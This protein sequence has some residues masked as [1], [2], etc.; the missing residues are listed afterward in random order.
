MN[1]GKA[2]AEFNGDASI[3]LARLQTE[4][5]RQ[6]AA[7]LGISHVSLY[8]WLL[9]NCP[10]EWRSLS[11][12]VQLAK[13]HDAQSSLD[14]NQVVMDSTTVSRVRESARIAMWNMSKTSGI[15][16]DKQEAAGMN[17]QVIINR[18][19]PAEVRVVANDDTHLT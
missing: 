11:T 1:A 8:A 9:R 14:D 10:E 16:A 19:E 13:L 15:Y 2:L 18:D 4:S 17:V 12:A 7:D 6:I 3:I 5:A